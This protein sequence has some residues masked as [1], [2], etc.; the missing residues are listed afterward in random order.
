[1][2]AAMNK[3]PVPSLRNPVTGPNQSHK[4]SRGPSMDGV[5]RKKPLPSWATD[6][7]ASK[8]IP[9]GSAPPRSSPNQFASSQRI[10]AD[11][12]NRTPNQ[13]SRT[14]SGPS[15]SKLVK[16]TPSGFQDRTPI[17]SQS[18]QAAPSGS[19]GKTIPS[20]PSRT[21]SGSHKKTHSP[22]S[23]RGARR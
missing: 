6:Q 18:G 15:P 7:L 10:P 8:S 2:Y 13:P 21:P 19:Y 3:R 23:S 12:R 9:S 1:M 20:Q 11:P 4:H 17:L 22:K 14:P 16:R 5:H